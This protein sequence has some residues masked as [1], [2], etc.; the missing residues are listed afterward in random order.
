M[1]IQVLNETLN[2]RIAWL[3]VSFGQL[4]VKTTFASY[5]LPE[6]L[7]LYYVVLFGIVQT[8]SNMIKMVRSEWHRLV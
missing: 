8:N 6:T 5:G 3:N 1:T 7:Y 4:P 2:D